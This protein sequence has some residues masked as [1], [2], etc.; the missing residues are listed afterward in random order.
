MGCGTY[1]SI[2][3]VGE[4]TGWRRYVERIAECGRV[5]RFDPDGIGLSDTPADLGELTLEAW[6]DD[7]RA[8]MDAV[9]SERAVVLAA[10]SSSLLGL[11]FAARHPERTESLIIINGTARYLQADD[12]PF[13]VPVGRMDAFRAGLDPDGDGPES[14]SLSDLHLFAPSA[15]D[16]P[17][18]DVGG[19][20]R[21]ST[22][23]HRP[24][25]PCWASSPHRRTSAP[26]SPASPH[27]HWSCTGG[28]LWLRPSSTAATSPTTSPEPVWSSFPGDDV[29][30]FAGDVD[31]LV[32]EI[33]EFITGNRYGPTP[34]RVL[35]TI[36]FTDIVD[37]TGTAARMGDRPWTQVLADHGALVR[38][39]IEHFEGQLVKDTG[40]GVLALFDGTTRAIR[41]A[42]MI[43]DGASHL[44]IQVRAG[45]HAGEVERRGHDVSGIAVHVAARV[46][47]EG[48]AGEVMVTNTV[49]DLV[50][51][52]GVSF[53]D[54]GVRELKGVPGHRHLW[55]VTAT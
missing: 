47:A 9:G 18:F 24:P 53:A 4:H 10:A 55:S 39:Q 5:I 12:Y 28:T 41:C 2:D 13:G 8:A 26:F 42:L 27:R 7:A 11:L 32:D 29:V 19:H 46:V 50:E 30:P 40:D 45:L 22:G 34:E 14:Q 3:E 1:I 35:A 17:D 31:A 25:P 23:L 54:R 20:G 37:S 21:Q 16:D 51:G 38:R 6:M 15:A 52:A 43:R 36:L 44:G 33:Q 48:E 49:V